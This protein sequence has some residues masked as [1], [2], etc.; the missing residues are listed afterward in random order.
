MRVFD[1]TITEKLSMT[2]TL[3]ADSAEAARQAVADYWKDGEYVLDAD[4][5][6]GV[7]FTA[8]PRPKSR[9]YER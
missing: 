3:E 2:V 1:V 7:S 5:F 4:H 8:R 9:D 6:Q